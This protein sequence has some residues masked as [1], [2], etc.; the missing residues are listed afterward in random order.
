M[1]TCTVPDVR[2]ACSVSAHTRSVNE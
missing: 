1:A 2:N